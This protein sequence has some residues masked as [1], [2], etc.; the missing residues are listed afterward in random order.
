VL[1]NDGTVQFTVDMNAGGFFSYKFT[2]QVVVRS[3]KG[4]IALILQK[5]GDVFGTDTPGDRDFNQTE[6]SFHPVVRDNWND[7]KTATMSVIKNYEKIGVVGTLGNVLTDILEYA[8]VS[9]VLNPVPGGSALAALVFV[10]SELGSLAN[11]RVSGPPG[12]GAP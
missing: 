6:T 3:A 12:Q 2:V 8:V 7:F 1:N 11:V 4:N 5:S 9:G 10:G